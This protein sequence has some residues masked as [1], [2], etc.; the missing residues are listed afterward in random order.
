MA[1]NQFELHQNVFNDDKRKVSQLLRTHD[2]SQ[3]DIHG[4]L[5]STLFT[6]KLIASYLSLLR[7][8]TQV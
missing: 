6:N 1:E 2:A 8:F 7:L 5:T 4:N 3:K